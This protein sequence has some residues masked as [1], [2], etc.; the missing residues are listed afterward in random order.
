[1]GSADR[2]ML[3]IVYVGLLL[4]VIVAA[5]QMA[6]SIFL[7]LDAGP[8]LQVSAGYAATGVLNASGNFLVWLAIVCFVPKA[9]RRYLCDKEGIA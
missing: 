3:K 8:R 2:V 1:M 5:L 6:Q 9:A 7:L 4:Y